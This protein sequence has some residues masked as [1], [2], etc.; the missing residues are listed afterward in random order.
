MGFYLRKILQKH[1]AN[2]GN[3]GKTLKNAAWQNCQHLPRSLTNPTGQKSTPQA[4]PRHI[5]SRFCHFA[6]HIGYNIME[7]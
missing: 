7:I 2:H 3:A 4:L 6:T 1:V 5:G